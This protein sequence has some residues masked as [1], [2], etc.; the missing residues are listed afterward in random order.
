MLSRPLA[1][2]CMAFFLVDY[3]GAQDSSAPVS[4]ESTTSERFQYYLKRTYSWQKMSWLA[5]DT[6]I[7]HLLHESEWGGGIGGY[8][9][10]YAS[11]FGRRLINNS[12]EL[13]AILILR[14]DTR[15]RRSHRTGIFPRI[16]YAATHAFLATN[17]QGKVEPAY[18]RFAGIS[19]SAL[20]APAWHNH[21]LS[22]VG[23]GQDLAFSSLDQVQNSLLAEFSPDLQR[24]GGAIK[25]KLLRK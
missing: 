5:V 9:C 25:K 17:E 4:D 3:A 12:I 14:Q 8:G 22:V 13:G 15:F 7:D 6:G 2:G 11:G 10:H 16:R 23:F 24:L 19:G 21:T 1:L 20:I 18:A